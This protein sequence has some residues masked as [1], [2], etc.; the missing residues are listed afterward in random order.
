MQLTKQTLYHI[1]RNDNYFQPTAGLQLGGTQLTASTSVSTG[2]GGLKTTTTTATAT[3]TLGGIKLGVLSTVTNTIGV[4]STTTTTQAGLTGST[5]L[6]LT[7]GLGGLG[8]GGSAVSQ[9]LTLQGRKGLGVGSLA[10]STAANQ[11]TATS[12][13]GGFRGLGGVDPNTSA[14]TNGGNGG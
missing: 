5:G 2:L 13:S 9:G 7:G 12:S 11:N 6:K 4:A 14:G 10:T 1:S 3:T 8:G